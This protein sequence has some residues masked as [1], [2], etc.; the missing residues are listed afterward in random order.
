[1]TQPSDPIEIAVEWLRSMERESRA[2]QERAVRNFTVV[3]I[4]RSV[5]VCEQVQHQLDRRAHASIELLCVTEGTVLRGH[6]VRA[7]AWWGPKWSSLWTNTVR[8]RCVIGMPLELVI[9]L[10]PMLEVLA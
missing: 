5:A 8:N 2:C 9:P 1:M 4:F 3:I 7:L 6:R 10:K